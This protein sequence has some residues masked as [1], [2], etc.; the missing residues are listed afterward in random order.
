MVNIFRK[1]MSQIGLNPERLGISFM[2]GS[3]ANVYVESVNDFVKK[4]KQLGPLGTGEGISGEELRVRFESVEKLIPYIRVVERE[5]LRVPVKS[6]EDVQ[7]FFSSD[8][9][10]GL[11]AELFEN[12]LSRIL[13][14]YIDPEKCKACMICSRQCPSEAIAG[15]KNLIHVIDQDKCTRCG[16]CFRACPS[17]F[18]AVQKISDEAPPPPVSEEARKI[19]RDGKQI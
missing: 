2:S 14:Y 7:S 16:C 8:E 17:R 9:V 12:K 5:R 4:I 18:G 13:S 15:G 10:N 3:E 19:V 11:F 6:E 1:L